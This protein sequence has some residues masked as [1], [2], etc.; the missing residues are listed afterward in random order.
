MHLNS[1]SKDYLSENKEYYELLE[2]L[3]NCGQSENILKY[4]INIILT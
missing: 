1:N 4:F 3:Y 2:Y